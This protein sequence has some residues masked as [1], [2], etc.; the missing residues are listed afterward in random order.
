MMGTLEAHSFSMNHIV[1]RTIMPTEFSH[2][3]MF[4][5]VFKADFAAPFPVR[6]AFSASGLAFGARVEVECIAIDNKQG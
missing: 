4:N 5:N 1:K 2:W 3:P 6:S